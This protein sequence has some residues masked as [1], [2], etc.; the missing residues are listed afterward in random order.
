MRMPLTASTPRAIKSS[1]STL[2]MGM[3]PAAAASNFRV[4]PFSSASLAS[5][6]PC[7][8]SSALLAVT[9]CLPLASAVSTSWRAMPSS[10][11]ISSTTTSASPVARD[12]GSSVQ[13]LT[14]IPLALLLS[15][16]ETATISSLRPARRDRSSP[17]ALSALTTPVPTVPRPAMAI[18]HEA[19][20][21]PR[22]DSFWPACHCLAYPW[23][24]GWCRP[25]G[26]SSHCAPPGGC[27]VHSPPAPRA[28]SPRH[29]HRSRCPA[30]PP[31]WRGLEGPWRIPSSTARGISPAPAPRRTWTRPAP[32]YPSPRRPCFSPAHRGAFYRRRGYRPRCPLAH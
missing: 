26:T 23:A 22:P 27:D 16:A 29:I 6:R 11:P 13:P 1:R 3:P 30:T 14:V 24:D 17:R 15:R 4:T 21:L 20:T 2:T 10:P 18:L 8:A 19:V 25:A 32:E 9:T 12:K 31:P 5:A 28:H 7:L